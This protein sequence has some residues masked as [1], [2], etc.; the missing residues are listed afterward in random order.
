MSAISCGSTRVWPIVL[1]N[2]PFVVGQ[3]FYVQALVLDPGRNAA[4]LA[5]S[6]GGEGVIR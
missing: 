6:N 1:P 5:V 4:G 2:L 3:D